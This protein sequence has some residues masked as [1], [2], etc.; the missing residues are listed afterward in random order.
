[1]TD[2]TFDD[3]VGNGGGID[4]G[5]SGSE[6]FGGIAEDAHE[7]PAVDDGK[8][9]HDRTVGDVEDRTAASIFGELKADVGNDA[10]DVLGDESPDDIIASADEPTTDSVW[11]DDDL[12]ADEEELETL[13][14][15][16]RTKGQEFL[17]VAPEDANDGER[18]SETE[19]ETGEKTDPETD[20]AASAPPTAAAES[21]EMDE[22]GSTAAPTGVGP[23][24]TDETRVALE[25]ESSDDPD[26]ASATN[27]TPLE[28]TS[29][30]DGD[31][32]SASTVGES[33]ATTATEATS[34][35]ET[36][37]GDEDESE[38]ESDDATGLVGSLLS[39]LNPF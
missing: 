31:E 5:S 15:T 19:T 30:L 33:G 7:E 16:G 32:S 36:D 12:V 9:D 1:M 38:G 29:T 21:A 35:E 26:E 37:S 34:T 17:W 27:P 23:G 6:L 10:D 20:G 18:S 4:V 8:P 24:E 25:A 13:L 39:T 22:N 14:L 28:S 2:S 11:P 3:D